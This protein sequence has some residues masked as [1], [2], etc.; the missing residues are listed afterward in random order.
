MNIKISREGCTRIAKEHG[1]N[2]YSKPPMRA[3]TGVS[4]TFEQLLAY[5]NKILEIGQNEGIEKAA[6]YCDDVLAKNH[7]MISEHF[8]HAAINI[9]AH[10]CLIETCDHSEKNH[11]NS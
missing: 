7:P 10:A 6:A 2:D 4:F 3:V 9:R 11:D 1:A 5:T 8:R